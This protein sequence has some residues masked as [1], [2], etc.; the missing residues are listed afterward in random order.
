MK[1]NPQKFRG[2]WLTGEFLRS[3]LSIMEKALYLEICALDNGHGCFASNQYYSEYCCVHPR[4]IK[5]YIAALKRAGYIRVTQD[6]QRR[7]IYVTGQTPR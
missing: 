1:K 3:N 4:T 5:R 6:C 2:I 7:M